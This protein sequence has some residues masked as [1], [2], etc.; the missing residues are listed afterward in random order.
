MENVSNT[1]IFAT[2]GTDPDAT[3]V[4]WHNDGRARCANYR[5]NT[6]QKDQMFCPKCGASL[7]ID[8]RE[9]HKPHCY[10]FS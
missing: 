7:G 4:T 3:E 2:L 10:G 5:F 1:D 9:V 8:F 6:K